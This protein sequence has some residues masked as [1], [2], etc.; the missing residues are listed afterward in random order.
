MLKLGV[1]ANNDL[2]S[3]LIGDLVPTSILLV[4]DSVQLTLGDIIEPR[5]LVHMAG[6]HSLR[7][8]CRVSGGL[9]AILE[10]EDEVPA[11]VDIEAFAALAL[12]DVVEELKLQLLREGLNHIF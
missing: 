11:L 3:V 7:P 6:L 5:G 2:E 8:G 10:K 12:A 1:R 9:V 4:C